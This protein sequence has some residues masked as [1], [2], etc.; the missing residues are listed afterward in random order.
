MEEEIAS[1]SAVEA[2]WSSYP[3]R[4]L[5]VLWRYLSDGLV[6]DGPELKA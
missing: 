5:V 6:P 2:R 4:D 3:N 1:A